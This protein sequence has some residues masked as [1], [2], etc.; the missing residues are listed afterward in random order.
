MVAAVD[1]FEPAYRKAMHDSTRAGPAKS[2]ATL[3]VSDGVDL[4]DA[5]A[6]Q[7]WIEA[8]NERPED[9]RIRLTEW[10]DS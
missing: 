4:T 9:E 8:F 5:D 1:E 6:V 2:I 10:S 7:E 3:M